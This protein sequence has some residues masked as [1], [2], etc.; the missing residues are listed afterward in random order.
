M[1]SIAKQNVGDTQL[2]E[3]RAVCGLM[4]CSASVQT[5]DGVPGP[6]VGPVGDA[7]CPELGPEL[8]DDDPVELEEFEDEELASDEL[9]DE[10]SDSELLVVSG[11]DE[12]EVSDEVAAGPDELER[13]EVAFGELLVWLPLTPASSRG[14]RAE[15]RSVVVSASAGLASAGPSGEAAAEVLS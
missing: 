7:V 12:F 6:V 14:V 1:V 15:V 10:D 11:S 2:T 3:V 5:R 4:I 13:V 9:L 8:P